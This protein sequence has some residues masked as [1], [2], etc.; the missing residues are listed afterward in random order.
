MVGDKKSNLRL[1]KLKLRVLREPTLRPL[2][3]SIYMN[4]LSM[5]AKFTLDRLL[6][7]LGPQVYF[8][9]R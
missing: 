2:A 8:V 7:E 5:R 9:F 6:I 3:F 1:A 4:Y